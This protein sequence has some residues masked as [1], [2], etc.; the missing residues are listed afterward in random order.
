MPTAAHLARLALHPGDDLAPTVPARPCTPSR[1]P[2][3]GA[4]VGR[5]GTR[6]RGP[7]VRRLRA[8]PRRAR[9]A[10]QQRLGGELDR[11]EAI[12]RRV[13]HA[14]PR[15]GRRPHRSPGDG[16]RRGVRRSRPRGLPATGPDRRPAG[17][18]R[19]CCAEPVSAPGP[20]PGR[21]R[22]ARA[23]R[24]GAAGA[25]GGRRR[26]PGDPAR[27]AAGR[28]DPAGRGGARTRPAR[29]RVGA[30]GH[31]RPLR[32][33]PRPPDLVAGPNASAVSGGCRPSRSAAWSGTP[34]SRPAGS[35]CR[36]TAG[37]GCV[38]PWSWSSR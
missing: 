5:P 13:V 22:R 27:T 9:L 28:P 15:A 18:D 14:V 36:R 11:L 19:S 32:D 2:L 7:G 1:D 38:R 29:R 3:P 4:G 23:R 17:Q 35:G 37:A 21:T 31:R 24:G 6:H 25:G 16:P 8:D 10:A 33:G 20:P 26:A 34:T 12:G 30:R